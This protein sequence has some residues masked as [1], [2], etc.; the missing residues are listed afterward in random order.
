MIS[1]TKNRPVEI[2]D[3]IRK[4]VE[5]D[6]FSD[7]QV[8]ET[9]DSEERKSP[10]KPKGRG[11]GFDRRKLA[12]LGALDASLVIKAL[13]CTSLLRGL[14][15]DRVFVFEA[16]LFLFLCL[17]VIEGKPALIEP[18]AEVMGL[19]E[20]ETRRF[21]DNFT[22]PGSLTLDQY[23]F[24]K[25]KGAQ[26]SPALPILYVKQVSIRNKLGVERT[27]HEA[28]LT[29]EGERIL[30]DLTETTVFNSD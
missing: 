8:N 21:I 5:E 20:N 27:V 3:Q 9:D 28:T 17:K 22:S 18:S 7:F 26:K 1:S 11:V 10:A 4:I 13:T 6:L 30:I 2:N 23:L 29:E 16:A 25:K 24:Q 19:N 15:D 12:E 14:K